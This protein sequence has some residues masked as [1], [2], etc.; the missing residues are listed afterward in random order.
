MRCSIFAA[1]FFF[2]LLSTMPAHANSPDNNG[3]YYDLKR[4]YECRRDRQ[5]YGEFYNY[6]Y[7]KGGRW[8]GRRMPGGYYVYK[9][10]VWYIWAGA[11]SAPAQTAP[12][13]QTEAAEQVGERQ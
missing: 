8:C 5:Q 2:A 11:R 12:S 9:D 10:G 3:Q 13:D 7:W 4:S 1:G 6:G